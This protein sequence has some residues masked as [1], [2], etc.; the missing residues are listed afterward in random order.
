MHA[1]HAT[2]LQCTNQKNDGT[3]MTS[4][5]I[6]KQHSLLGDD[7]KRSAVESL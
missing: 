4:L 7:S 5:P 6:V 1:P 2:G 3:E